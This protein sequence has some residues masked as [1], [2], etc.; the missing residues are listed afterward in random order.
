MLAIWRQEEDNDDYIYVHQSR[1][2]CYHGET[3]DRPHDLANA[4]DTFL[5]FWIIICWSFYKDKI[6]DDGIKYSSNAQIS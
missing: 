3:V 4:I 2:H 6:D 1:G 5:S